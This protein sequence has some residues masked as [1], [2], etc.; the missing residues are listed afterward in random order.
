MTYD[1]M[2]HVY[3]CVLADYADLN[4]CHNDIETTYKLHINDMKSA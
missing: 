2:T 3:I 4:C 1:I